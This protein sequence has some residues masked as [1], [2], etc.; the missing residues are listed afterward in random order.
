MRNSGTTRALRRFAAGLPLI[1]VPLLLSATTSVYAD[2]EPSR[3]APCAAVSVPAGY[4]CVP[5][6]KQCLVAPCPQYAIV[7]IAPVAPPEPERAPVGPESSD[8]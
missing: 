5:E 8:R 7:P 6:P 4:Q 2:P 1:A 3:S